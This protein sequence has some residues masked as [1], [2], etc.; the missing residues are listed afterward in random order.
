MAVTD[1]KFNPSNNPVIDGIKAGTIDME[2]FVLDN[3]PAGRRRSHA[4]TIL[5]DFSMWAVK[6]AAVGDS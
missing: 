3:I 1:R 2:Q 5:E 4:L 6:A